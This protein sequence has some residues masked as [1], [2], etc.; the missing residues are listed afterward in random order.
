MERSMNTSTDID[1]VKPKE[2]YIMGVATDA[3]KTVNGI[4]K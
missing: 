4:H 1:E 3:A 2:G